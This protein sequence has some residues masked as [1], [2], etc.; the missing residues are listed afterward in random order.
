MLSLL[1]LP[2]AWRRR[3]LRRQ[4]RGGFGD[5]VKSL[6]W[7]GFK[8]FAPGQNP[9]RVGERGGIERQA[10]TRQGG[11]LPGLFGQMRVQNAEMLHPRGAE[12]GGEPVHEAVQGGL[13]RL[14]GIEAVLVGRH[15]LGQGD[16]EA[17]QIEAEAGIQARHLRHLLREQA[18]DGEG[19]AQRPA[20][21]H[22]QP[23]HLPV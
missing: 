22:L 11:G 8:G 4:A 5:G 20:G 12:A 21:A 2:P 3:A 7:P 18:A 10:L 1:P 16:A 23:R 17:Q 14:P 13:F 19:I 15:L 6:A 9:R